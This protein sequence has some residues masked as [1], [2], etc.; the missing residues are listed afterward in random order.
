MVKKKTEQLLEDALIN[1]ANMDYALFEFEL[2]DMVEEMILSMVNDDDEYI[3][4]VTVNDGSVAMAL[5]ERSG[6]MFVNESA[7][8]KLKKLWKTAYSVNMKKLIPAYANE[9]DRGLIPIN[10]IK[11]VRN[12][13]DD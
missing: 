13:G 6:N 2:A 8:D 1:D 4:S 10:G 5:I 11:I 3:L 12:T 9:L 7:R